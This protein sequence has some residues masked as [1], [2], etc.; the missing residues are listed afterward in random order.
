MKLLIG[1]LFVL[2]VDAAV[3][4]WI[5]QVAVWGL[6]LFHVDSGIWGP[7]LLLTVASAVVSMGVS[8]GI[9]ANK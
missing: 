7:M 2:A 6:S 5:A 4:L 9:S 1:V 8:I 3:N